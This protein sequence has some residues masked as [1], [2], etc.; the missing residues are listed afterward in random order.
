MGSDG[1]S[2]ST[3]RPDVLSRNSATKS[4]QPP[5]ADGLLR[6]AGEGL[7]DRRC[8]LE[9]VAAARRADDDPPVPLEQEVLVRC[10]R[11]EAGF[12]A[13]RLGAGSGTPAPDPLRQEA[14]RLLVGPALLVRLGE[15]A[16]H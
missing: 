2:A 16:G 7:A 12:R 6:Q 5:G 11:V 14:H 10:R 15:R 8:E 4:L 1:S 13:D 9:A 3:A